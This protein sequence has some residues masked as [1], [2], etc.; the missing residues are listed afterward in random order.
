MATLLDSYSESN[1]DSGEGSLRY[2]GILKLGQSFVG[3]GQTLDSVKFYIRKNG[4]P[5][6]NITAE[7]FAHSGTFGVSS[8]GTGSALATSDALAA[9]S[10]SSS[11][12]LTTFSFSGANRITLENGVNYVVVFSYS[13]IGSD[14]SNDV[15]YVWDQS[16]PSHAG[17]Y[18]YYSDGGG[19]GS[20]S[21]RDAPFYVYVDSTISIS[22]SEVIGVT[23]SILKS[24][25]ISVLETVGSA[26][27]IIDTALVS[28]PISTIIGSVK[29]YIKKIGRI[30][31]I[32]KI[33]RIRDVRKT[34]K[35]SDL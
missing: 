27:L 17:N 14:I 3:N 21:G 18:L 4:S 22:V 20:I 28:I 2:T 19:W 33:G 11:L 9:S 23:E 1:A 13:D 25:S 7:I 24:I 26:I 34:G 31:D 35:L 8:V 29:D 5:P 6:G 10:L 15:R 12:S 16:S 32:K 30:V